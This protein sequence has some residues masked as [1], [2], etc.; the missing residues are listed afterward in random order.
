MRERVAVAFLLP[1]RLFTGWVF[2]TAGLSKLFAGW[3]DKPELAHVLSGWLAQGLPYRFYAPFLRNVV[4]PHA[5]VFSVLIVFGEIAVGV[6]LLAG[7]F[8]RLAALGGLV[9]VTA[10][11][12]GRGD[13]ASANATA[14]FI[15]MTITLALTSP[16]RALGLDGALR[17]KVPGWLS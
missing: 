2:M 8:S 1:L 3:L 5:K 12:L 7:L 10:F 15:A 11:L 17:G 14:P 9:L 13:G 6:A 4:L 16:G